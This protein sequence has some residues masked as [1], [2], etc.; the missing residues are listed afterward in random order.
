LKDDWEQIEQWA[1]QRKREEEFK[2]WVAQL[3]KEIPVIIK[4]DI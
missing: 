3:R 4:T 2:A 1:L